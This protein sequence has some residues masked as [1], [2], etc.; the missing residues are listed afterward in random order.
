MAPKLLK[1]KNSDTDSDGIVVFNLSSRTG[2]PDIEH[3][4][5]SGVVEERTFLW[6]LQAE[7]D[8]TAASRSLPGEMCSVCNE[9]KI[10][11]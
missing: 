11:F 1:I 10:R 8:T 4:V 2:V 6:R 7:R 9:Q 3:D 5:W